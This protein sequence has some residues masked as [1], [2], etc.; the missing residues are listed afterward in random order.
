MTSALHNAIADGL[1]LRPDADD[2]LGY[3]TAYIDHDD[4]ADATVAVQDHLFERER[5]RAAILSGLR[6]SQHPDFADILKA[7]MAAIG[8]DA[9]NEHLFD[10]ELFVQAVTEGLVGGPDQ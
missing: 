6:R 9:E 4:V 1:G 10:D 8:F 5:V 2:P 3:A 7:G